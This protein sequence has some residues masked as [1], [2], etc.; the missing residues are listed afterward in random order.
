MSVPFKAQAQRAAWKYITLSILTMLGQAQTPPTFEVASVKPAAHGKPDAQ[1]NSRSS[2]GAV[3]PGNFV[4]E[5]NSLDE[6]IRFAYHLNEYQVVGPPWLN[7]KSES[8]D[9]I[10]KAPPETS[11]EQMRPMVQHLLIERFK[12]AAHTETR[13]RTIFELVRGKNEP[14]L[15]AADSAG[16]KGVASS[17]G[18][19]SATKVTINDFAVAL[20]RFLKQP[21]FDKTGITGTFDITFQYALD[22]DVSSGAPSL[23]TA[24]KEA[25]GLVLKSGKGPVEILVVDHIE[26]S[27]T[28]N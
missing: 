15:K 16:R 2:A 13:Q 23:F 7:D 22:G 11:R 25:T 3:S 6:L 4:A 20:S 12:L 10:A 14:K 26:K 28:A 27:P 19:V 18:R 1:G 5:N 24:I 21:V 8:F 17:G 9:I